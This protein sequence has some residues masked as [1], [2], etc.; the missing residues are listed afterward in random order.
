M[1]KFVVVLVV[2][3]SSCTGSVAESGAGSPTESAGS[4]TESDESLTDR[5]AGDESSVEMA[6]ETSDSVN[7]DSLSGDVSS[8]EAS[9]VGNG[10]CAPADVGPGNL[11]IESGSNRYDV[12]VFVPS[13]AQTGESLPLVMNWHGLGSSGLEQ[14]ALTDFESVAEREGFIVV[15]P[16]GLVIPGSATSSWELD[17]T[18]IPGRDDLAFAHDLIDTMIDGHCVDATRVYSTGMS[19]GGFF[20]S[21]LVCELSD[22]L[23]AASS[24][25]GLSHF[26]DCAPERAVPFIGFHGTDDEVVPFGGGTSRLSGGDL[27]IDPAFFEQKM[28]QEFGEFAEGAS[29]SST[30]T[31]VSISDEVIR[32]DYGD[33]DSGVTMSF[34]EIV[35]GGHTWPGSPLGVFLTDSLGVTTMDVSATELS[36]SFFQ[37]HHLAIG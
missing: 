27:E 5:P 15:H 29:C 37:E 32:H 33:C 36:W 28:P 20:T 17:G 12:R 11:Q 4:S 22:R 34:Y 25:A 35:G 8:E 23:A 3:A 9:K 13:A 16:T 26:E 31:A 21:R 6:S 7:A 19:N 14:V 10:G 30:L 24:I 2:A 18:S 1:A